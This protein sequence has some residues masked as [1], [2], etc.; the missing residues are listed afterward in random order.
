M[1]SG[2]MMLNTI[3]ITT[4]PRARRRSPRPAAVVRENAARVPRSASIYERYEGCDDR[5]APKTTG[6]GRTAQETPTSVPW[7]TA[8]SSEPNTTQR[9]TAEMLTRCPCA[10]RQRHQSER[11]LQHLRRRAGEEQRNSIM[12]RPTTVLSA[13]TTTT[14]LDTTGRRALA[15]FM[16]HAHLMARW[17]DRRPTAPPAG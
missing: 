10:G 5:Q 4:I 12:T 9:V 15:A 14:L 8:V 13:S 3:E 1:K 11:S 16:N 7:T 2:R 17:R 6:E